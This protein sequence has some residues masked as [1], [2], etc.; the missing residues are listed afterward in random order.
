VE[1][2]AKDTVGGGTEGDWEVEE[3]VEEPGPSGG[4]EVRAGGT[5]LPPPYGRGKAG[6]GRGGRS[7]VCNFL[8]VYH[9]FSGQAWAEGKRGACNVPP[10]RGQQTGNGL[11]IISP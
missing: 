5:G 10:L 1:G 11:Y 4:R 7:F 2:P 6:A 3:P 9:I 8:G